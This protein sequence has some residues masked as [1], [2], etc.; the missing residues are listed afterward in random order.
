VMKLRIVAAF[1]LLLLLGGI[2]WLVLRSRSPYP[3]IPDLAGAAPGRLALRHGEVGGHPADF[4]TLAVLEDWSD[5]G[6]RRLPLP[7]VRIR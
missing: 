6:S 5:P 4:G 2:G 1:A 7:L 3:S